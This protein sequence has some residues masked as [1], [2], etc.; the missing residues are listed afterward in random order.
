MDE[1]TVHGVLAVAYWGKN[2]TAAARIAAEAW[3]QSP[4][5]GTG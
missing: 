5:Q 4:A 1:E 3:V 2:L